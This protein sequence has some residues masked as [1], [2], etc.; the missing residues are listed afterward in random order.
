M[1]GSTVSKALL[2]LGVLVGVVTGVALALGLRLD[3][4]PPWIES[5]R[6]PRQRDPVDRDRRDV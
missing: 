1:R 2:L 5:D 3:R 4:L 6:I